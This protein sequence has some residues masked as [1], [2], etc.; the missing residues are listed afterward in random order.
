MFIC[1]W[2]C[3][4]IKR[5]T[6]KYNQFLYSYFN[7]NQF[8]CLNA[9]INKLDQTWDLL[10][11]SMTL[12]D[13]TDHSVIIIKIEVISFFHMM[14]KPFWFYQLHIYWANPLSYHACITS[15]YWFFL[16]LIYGL[17]NIVLMYCTTSRNK[18]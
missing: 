1:L 11:F 8:T 9:F 16:Q 12:L 7:K 15:Y 5:K 6:I 2:L 4:N 10:F 3:T 17:P 13:A 18:W 14:Q